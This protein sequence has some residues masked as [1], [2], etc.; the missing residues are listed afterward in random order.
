M[1]ANKRSVGWCVGSHVTSCSHRPRSRSVR[2]SHL[3]VPAEQPFDVANVPLGILALKVCVC[4]CVCVLNL[5]KCTPP[6]FCPS[7]CLFSL[8]LFS[9]F[10]PFDA[11]SPGSR[12]ALLERLAR[13]REGAGCVTGVVP[14]KSH[15]EPARMVAFSS[16]CAGTNSE[17][18]GNLPTITQP[19]SL[20]SHFCVLIPKSTLFSLLLNPSYALEKNAHVPLLNEEMMQINLALSW[21]T[22]S[23]AIC[24]FGDD[25]G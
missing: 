22:G 7:P 3:P 4:V 1:S 6:T 11:F 25:T 12:L 19:S 18:L 24:R 14:S 13:A 20:D 21:D 8:M 15:G 23:L 17:P 2:P 9:D 5:R 10:L 16:F